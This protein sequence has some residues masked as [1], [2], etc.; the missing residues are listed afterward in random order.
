MISILDHVLTLQSNE[1]LGA[2][3]VYD[4]T[5]RAVLSSVGRSNTEVIDLQE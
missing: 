1:P 2:Y 3:T 4:I 5:G